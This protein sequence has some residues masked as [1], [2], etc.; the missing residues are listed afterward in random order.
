MAAP[1]VTTRQTPGGIMLTNGY[2]VRITF[3]RFPAVKFME[4]GGSPPSIDGGNPIDVTTQFNNTYMTYAPN[5][6]VKMGEVKGTAAY[7]P[8]VYD[9]I[10]SMVNVND[11]VTFRYPDGSTVAFWGFLQKVDFK[12]LEQGKQPELDFTVALTM[13]DNSGAEQ[14]F[15][16]TEVA[17]T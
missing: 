7:D 6:L 15:V 5:G 3:K 12:S 8:A 17:G 4:K 9:T 1:T 2:P 10:M 16:L 11:E 14:A 13:R